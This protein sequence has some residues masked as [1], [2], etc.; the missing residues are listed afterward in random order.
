MKILVVIDMQ[1]DFIDGTLGTKEAKAI[2]PHIASRVKQADGNTLVLFT[3]D[4]HQE[5]YLETSEGKKLPVVH[6]I[7]NSDGWQLDP[8]ILA[9]WEHNTK[10]IALSER[11]SHFYHKPVFGCVDL[12]E[13]LKHWENELTEIEL[14]GVCTDICVVS[15]ALMIK[16]SL[17]DVKITVDASLCAGVTKES[18]T[19]SLTVMKMCHVD[20]INEEL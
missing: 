1:K 6:C 16:N 4:T 15:N 11:E 8:E 9:A 20:V 10:T 2:V 3:L 5:N 18:H 19:A 7:E 12:V 13:D 14:I 17:P